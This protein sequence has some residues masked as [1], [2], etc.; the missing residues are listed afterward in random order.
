MAEDLHGPAPRDAPADACR[1]RA[2][3]TLPRCGV[4]EGDAARP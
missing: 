3:M 4:D 2:A 1:K